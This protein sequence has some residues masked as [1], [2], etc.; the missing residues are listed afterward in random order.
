MSRDPQADQT[1]TPEE[2][3]SVALARWTAE[4]EGE[5]VPGAE[6]PTVYLRR[7][8]EDAALSAFGDCTRDLPRAEGLFRDGVELYLKHQQ[9]GT[10][11]DT[12]FQA[13][14]ER[15]EDVVPGVAGVK[16]GQPRAIEADAFWMRLEQ[17]VGG[18]LDVFASAA[19]RV[20]PGEGALSDERQ[21]SAAIITSAVVAAGELVGRGRVSKE[22][23]LPMRMLERMPTITEMRTSNAPGRCASV[24]GRAIESVRMWEREA[25]EL[26]AKLGL[27]G[28]PQK[29]ATAAAIAPVLVSSGGPMT[30]GEFQA[31]SGKSR[32]TAETFLEQLRQRGL[33]AVSSSGERGKMYSFLRTAAQVMRGRDS[34]EV[35]MRKS[36]R[37]SAR[38]VA[39]LPA[40][41]Q[42]R[43]RARARGR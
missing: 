19:P 22:A 16:L 2:A 43:D 29:L 14:K 26:C 8:R 31:A 27:E 39:E 20:S 18:A 12:F 15:L 40:E 1:Y 3:A 37:E 5:W 36:A 4:A 34:E 10:E 32:N 25:Q 7:V 6:A 17:R 42:T 23:V 41:K 30:L 24:Y 11:G 28:S 38:E 13:F 21:Q 9:S 35:T 33:V